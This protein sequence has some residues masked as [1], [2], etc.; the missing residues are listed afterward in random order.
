MVHGAGRPRGAGTR[1][2]GHAMGL[3]AHAAG[4]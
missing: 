4:I 3:A 1:R 2:A